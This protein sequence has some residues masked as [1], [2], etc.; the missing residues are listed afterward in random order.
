MVAEE[1]VGPDLRRAECVGDAA[2]RPGVRLGDQQVIRAELIDVCPDTLGDGVGH[3]VVDVEPLVGELSGEAPHRGQHEMCALTMPAT[4]G[5]QLL[6]LDE[7]HAVRGRIGTA[8]G[9]EAA[10][11]LI[12]EHPHRRRS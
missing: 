10:V 8:E 1:L 9:T 2:A 11:E 3:P 12:T 7:Q 4:S 6:P 5:E